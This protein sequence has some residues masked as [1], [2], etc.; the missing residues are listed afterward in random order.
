M[1]IE[2]RIGQMTLVFQSAGMQPVKPG[3]PPA[4][5]GRSRAGV[6]L[7]QGDFIAMHGPTLTIGRAPDNQVVLADQQASSHH[8]RLVVEPDGVAI[9]DLGSTNGTFVNDQQTSRQLLAQGDRIRIGQAE[10][11]FR[12]G[13]GQEGMYDMLEIA[14]SV[15]VLVVV[16]MSLAA[17]AGE[18]TQP[19][20][21]FA[22]I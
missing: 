5:A 1:A 13:S 22:I 10:L 8:A 6:Q 11:I 2:I 19:T 4:P 7:A 21:W 14:V 18:S 12:V 17:C 15:L 9:E 16:V 20:P 3:A